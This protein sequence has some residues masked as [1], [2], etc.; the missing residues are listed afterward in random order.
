MRKVVP[1]TFLG[2]L[3]LAVT[4]CGTPA[5]W[6]KPGVSDVV[7]ATD[8]TECR[9]AASQEAF[10]YAPYGWGLPLWPYRRGSWFYWQQYQ[11]SQRFYAENR[12]TAFC[13]RNKG[14]ELVPIP[15]PQG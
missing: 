10:L 11:D 5:R 12:L 3:L 7:T 6:E 9:R 14:Y 13:M 1:A 2:A 8:I 15:K 4:G